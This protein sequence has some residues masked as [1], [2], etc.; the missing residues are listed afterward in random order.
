MNDHLLEVWCP[1]DG[2]VP[3]DADEIVLIPGSFNPF[4][5]GHALLTHIVREVLGH[6]YQPVYELSR[7]NF[8]KP[9]LDDEDVNSRING[10]PGY[11][12][13][14]R[15]MT[16]VEKFEAFEQE[17]GLTCAMIVGADVWDRVEDKDRPILA[18]R[19]LIIVGRPGYEMKTPIGGVMEFVRE[20]K[21]FKPISSTQ[22][23]KNK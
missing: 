11:V 7:K 15:A 4:H 6:S 23:R 22:I 16:L 14:T 3:I 10:I 20:P 18:D 21:G 12:W 5:A 2:L 17:T 9:D 8:S 13:E 19:D 1:F